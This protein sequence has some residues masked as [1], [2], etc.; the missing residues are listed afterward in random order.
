MVRHLVFHSH[1]LSDLAYEM[2]FA[3]EDTGNEGG[4]TAGHASSKAKNKQRT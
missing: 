2:V 3:L 4:G 1:I